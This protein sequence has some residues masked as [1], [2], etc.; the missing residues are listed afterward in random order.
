MEEH[1]EVGMTRTTLGVIAHL[2]HPAGFDMPVKI[3]T[4][5]RGDLPSPIYYKGALV[6]ALPDGGEFI[7]TV[8]EALQ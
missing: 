8:A 7:G 3:R 5:D 1:T 2:R 4:R 6:Y